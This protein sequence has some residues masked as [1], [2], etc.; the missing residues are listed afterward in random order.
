MN[1]VFR[2]DPFG[3]SIMVYELT[4]SEIRGLLKKTYRPYNKQIDLVPSGMRYQIHTHEGKVSRITLTDMQGKPL[5][6][7]R[8][9][10]VGMNSYISSSYQFEHDLPATEL[11]H[12]TSDALIEYLKEQ[13]S[14]LPQKISRGI[15]TE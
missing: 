2:L 15:I 10:K 1:D 6:E 7:K 13:K 5:E 3:N 8:R 11:P 12:T 4:P 14:I 9:Y